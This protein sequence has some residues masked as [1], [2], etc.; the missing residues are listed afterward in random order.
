MI[1][2]W[3]VVMLLGLWL[4]LGAIDLFTIEDTVDDDREQA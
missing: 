2:V 3:V 1:G 4:V